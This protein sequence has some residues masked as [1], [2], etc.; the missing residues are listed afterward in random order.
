MKDAK[1]HVILPEI[2]KSERKSFYLLALVFLLALFLRA[3]TVS[4]GL[5]FFYDEDEAHHYNRTVNMVKDGDLNPHYFHKPSLHFYLRMP[6]VVASYLWSKSKGYLNSMDEVRTYN[7]YGLAGY[8]FTASH[9]GM[10]K[11]NRALSLCFSLALILLTFLISKE[12][13]APDFVSIAAALFTA[14]SPGLIDYA[15]VIGVDGLMAMMCCIAVY[16]SLKFT[17]NVTAKYL[18]LASAFAGLAISSKYN[19]LPVMGAPFVA[20]LCTRTFN[21]SNFSILSLTSL[22]FFFL[23]S[24]FILTSIN[25][26]IDDLQYEVWHYAVAGHVGHTA[27]PGLQQVMFYA[28]WFSTDAVGILIAIFALYGFLLFIFNSNAQVLTFLS[29]PLLYF[30]LMCAQ[31]ANFVRNMLVIIPFL[32]IWAAYGIYKLCEIIIKPR[33]V[34]RLGRIAFAFFCILQPLQSDLAMRDEDNSFE[35]SRHRLLKW[36]AANN[37]EDIETA[38]SGQLILPREFYSSQNVLTIDELNRSPIDLYQAGFDRLIL[39][40]GIRDTTY[41]SLPFLETEYSL[42]GEEGKQRIV[43]NPSISV[44]KFKSDNSPI[45]EAL[46]EIGNCP[47][48]TLSFKKTSENTYH[49]DPP[50]KKDEPIND[51]DYCWAQKRLSVLNLPDLSAAANGNKDLFIEFE[52]M[53]PWEGQVISVL[54]DDQETKIPFKKLI[55]GKWQ[56]VGL[57]LSAAK[58][59][60][61]QILI[62]SELVLSPWKR[63]LSSD[64]RRLAF[65]VRGITVSSPSF[66]K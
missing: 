14:L 31:R 47:D 20:L 35:E 59:E 39:G 57:K 56:N 66:T 44:Y 4:R 62:L 54:S 19:A 41:E 49:C 22:G 55:P 48:C 10:V 2:M 58:L 13:G 17:R 36:F 24:P 5:P 43:K 64:K 1:K 27:E 53:T 60:K 16:F 45:V 46:D 26:F 38:V 15:S 18:L 32:N 6:V 50:Q 9:P 63:G 8:A 3:H 40:K 42:A 33:E 37:S 52:V 21:K 25:L 11:W 34:S 7:R 65:A 51:E 29:F 12:I 30:I 61:S 28:N 23:A